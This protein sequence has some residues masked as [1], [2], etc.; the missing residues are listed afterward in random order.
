LAQIAPIKTMSRI[1]TPRG[2][3]TV[4]PGT[5]PIGGVAW[6]IHRGIEAVEV[7][8]DDGPWQ[9][10]QLGAVPGQ[11]TWRQWQFPWEATSGRHTIAVRATDGDGVVQTEER[12]EPIPDGASGWHSI[13]VTV[14]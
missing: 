1:D 14:R 8:V 4:D 13:V 11:D 2:L 6:A 10:A 7:R 3:A 9:P 12:A 5:V